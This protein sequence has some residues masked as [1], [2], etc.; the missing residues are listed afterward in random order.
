MTAPGIGAPLVSRT[1]P[2][3]Y[4]YSPFPSDAIDSPSG[5]AGQW[6]GISLRTRKQASKRDAP[7]G[8]SSVKNGPRLL[9]SVSV[10]TRGLL[11]ASTSADPPS[12][13]KIR[14]NSRCG[15][16]VCPARVRN[17]MAV[18][19]SSVVIL[20]PRVIYSIF[21]Q[22]CRV[23]GSGAI[24]GTHRVSLTNSWSLVMRIWKMNL[25]RLSSSQQRHITYDSYT[26]HGS[27]VSSVNLSILEVMASALS[28][29]CRMAINSEDESIVD[30]HRKI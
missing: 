1:C 17:S 25:T 29:Y 9:L 8:A 12:T 15:A 2:C 22:A 19:H 6:Y 21:C 16:F 28:G 24:V 14:E 13:L 30:A 7:S 26:T 5:T 23:G 3:T 18:I 27:G 10:L 11:S 4:I 20:W